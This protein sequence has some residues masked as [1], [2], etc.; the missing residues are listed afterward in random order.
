MTEFLFDTY[1]LLEI[2]RGNPRYQPY[3]DSAPMINSF[4]LAELSYNL[5]KE[6]GPGTAFSYV[7]KYAPF[8]APIDSGLIKEASLFRFQNKKKNFSFTDCA[9]YCQAKN[10]GIR[11]LTGDKEF[12]GLPNVEFVK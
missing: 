3:L 1:A 10:L 8:S 12:Q 6:H 4:I 5:L 9:G 2:I 7:D 11:F